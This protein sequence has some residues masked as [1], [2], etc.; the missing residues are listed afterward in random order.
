MP[1]P[2]EYPPAYR[3]LAERFGPPAAIEEARGIWGTIVKSAET[4]TVVTLIAP[5]GPGSLDWAAV[6]PLSE[7]PDPGRCPVWPLSTARA[8][9]GEVVAAATRFPSPVPQILARH[10]QPT[11]AVIAARALDGLPGDAE[12]IDLHAF[13]EEGGT[14]TLAYDPGQ[15]G[16]CDEGGI[17]TTDPAQPAFLATALG[18]DGTV[19]GSGS[20]P[21]V[22][23]AMLRVYR[24][25]PFPDPGDSGT[26]SDE[27]PF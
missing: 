7:V 20:G 22:A 21:T 12:R 13:L 2:G 27:A 24:Q 9:L 6:V 14:V 17:V 26:R 15:S 1:E 23:E 16:A 25:P 4:G 8:R 19:V 5:G 3:K 10:R 18:W 11:A